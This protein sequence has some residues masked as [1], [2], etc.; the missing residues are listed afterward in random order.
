MRRRDFL[1]A[2][3][4]VAA[5]TFVPGFFNIAKAGI[6]ANSKV[7]VAMIGGGGIAGQAYN[8]CK[9]ENIVA[10]CDVDESRNKRE[11]ARSFTDF[12][13]MFDKM[14]KEIDAV[15]VNAPDHTHFGATIEAMRRGKHV[16]TQKPLTHNLWQS[17]TLIKAA[18]KY[19]VLTNM[20]NQG[21][22]FD[23]IRTMREWYEA[24]ILGQVSEVHSGFPGPKWNSRYFKMP[25]TM[26]PAKQPVPA[27]LNWDL[28]LGPAQ[29]T[30]YNSI[31]HPRTWRSFWDYGTGEL[32]DWFCHICDGPAWILDLFD[33]TSVEC[34]ERKE[35]IKGVVTS[36]S[37]VRWKFPKRGDKIACDLYWS[38]GENKMKAPKN[39]GHGREPR[40][41]SHWYANKNNAYLD[42]RSN[43]PR[44]SDRQKMVEMQKANVFPKEK[45]AR[46]KGRSPHKELM[47]AI[48]G[49]SKP[50]SSFEYS[51]RLTETCL[52]GVLAQRFGG[53]IEWDA[54][55]LKITNRPELNA[56]VKEPVRNGWEDYGTDLW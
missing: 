12:R 41:G 55:N 52:L 14:G 33:P 31:F 35:N 25:E 37:I 2:A 38:D 47:D 11:G 32:G 27:G 54:K 4:V 34:L 42:E 9:D 26:P 36:S 10:I 15:C 8:G 19:K 49:G 6:S 46:V 48:K 5:G 16:C 45:Y 20:G 1:G 24:G 51:A 50:G 28:W 13:V 29:K 44:L 23:G 7:N 3:G 18:K 21:H 17:R 30:A 56:F 40:S 53:K 22:T 39:W 43:N